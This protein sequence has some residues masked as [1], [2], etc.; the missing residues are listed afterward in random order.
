MLGDYRE[1]IKPSESITGLTV[2]NP[3]QK[4]YNGIVLEHI[5][6]NVCV[7]RWTILNNKK[8]ITIEF[9]RDLN[10]K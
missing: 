9:I 3:E 4:K 8:S 10:I 1:L 2:S 7:V 6:K 5:L